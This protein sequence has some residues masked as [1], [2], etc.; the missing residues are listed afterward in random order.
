MTATISPI[1]DEPNK[2]NLN[3]LLII[4]QGINLYVPNGSFG[5]QVLN[6]N[7]NATQLPRLNSIPEMSK[8]V[9]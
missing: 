3:L 4:F 9:Y 7:K 6:M 5:R 8:L 1:Q 2:K